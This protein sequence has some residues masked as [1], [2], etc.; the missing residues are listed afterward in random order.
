LTTDF[1]DVF[2]EVAQKHLGTS[3]LANVFPG[4]ATSPSKFR[5]MLG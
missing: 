4:Y 2:G 5:G 1:R 3:N